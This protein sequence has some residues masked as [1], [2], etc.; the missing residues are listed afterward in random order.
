MDQPKHI[1]EAQI[2][3]NA[4]RIGRSLERASY[5]ELSAL[6]EEIALEEMT[7]DTLR[8]SFTATVFDDPSNDGIIVELNSWGSKSFAVRRWPGYRFGKRR[9]GSVYYP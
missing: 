7:F 2:L 8:V 5:D 6:D 1:L 3:E 9:D 4:R